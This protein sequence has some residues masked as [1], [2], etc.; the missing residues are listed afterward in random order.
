MT[1]KYTF[2]LLLFLNNIITAQVGIE[3]TSPTATLDV[4]GKLRVRN[5]PSYNSEPAIK[6]SIVIS[7]GLGNIKRVSSKQIYNN[8]IKT[9]VKG[10]FASTAT[11]SLSILSGSVKIPFDFVDFDVNTEFNTTTNSFSPKQDGIYEINVQIKSGGVLS[12]STNFGVSILNNGVIVNRNNFPNVGVLGVNVTPP[13]RYLNTLVQLT[14]TDIITFRINSD[15]LSITL[16]G[17]KEDCFFTIKQ[18]R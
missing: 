1:K 11:L 8:N 2:I 7:D 16:L 12:A 17:T 18:V 3:T 15:L 14:T 4:N 13:I 10:S 6:D 5:L 9:F